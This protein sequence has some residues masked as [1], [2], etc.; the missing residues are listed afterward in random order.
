MKSLTDPARNANR[1]AES[2]DP[3]THAREFVFAD[4]R[5]RRLRGLKVIV[6]PI[7][8]V[9]MI[10]VSAFTVLSIRSPWVNMDFDPT[11]ISPRG[12]ETLLPAVGSGPVQRVLSVHRADGKIWGT[13]PA[14][15][16][17][18][19][20]FTSD[21]TA[22]IGDAEHVLDKSGYDT[23]VSSP[24]MVPVLGMVVSR[25]TGVSVGGAGWG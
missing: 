13:D 15:G 5:G 22:R 4:P 3:K 18:I 21:E 24:R 2:A 12:A 20:Q 16:A 23:S 19:R 1:P 9:F 17:W 11:A 14:T 25:P 8:A 10:T 6:I 7:L